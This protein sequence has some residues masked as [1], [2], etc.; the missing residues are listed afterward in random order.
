MTDEVCRSA[1]PQAS[2]QE[3]QLPEYDGNPLISA[4]PPIPG[5]QKW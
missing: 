1:I 3:Q 2:Y 5:F 4:L